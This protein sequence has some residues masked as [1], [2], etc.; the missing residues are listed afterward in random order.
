M[1]CFFL[2]DSR[3]HTIP[4]T[5]VDHGSGSLCISLCHIFNFLAILSDD[6]DDRNIKFLC[7][8]KVTVIM[9]RNAHDCTGTVICKD[10]VRQPD[11]CLCAI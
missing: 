11:W 8:F 9:S 5:G 10:V 1:R 3:L 6:L 7:K 2:Q 4:L